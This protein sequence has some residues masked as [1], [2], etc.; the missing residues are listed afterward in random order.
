MW[1]LVKFGSWCYRTN[2][3]VTDVMSLQ[4]RCYEADV[5]VVSCRETF[6]M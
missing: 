5:V 4:P 3:Y 6:C 1:H 2:V